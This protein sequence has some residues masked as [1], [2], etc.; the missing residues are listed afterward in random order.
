MGRALEMLKVAALM[1][2]MGGDVAA[3][4]QQK[5]DLWAVLVAGS[6]S[7]MNY[8]HQVSRQPASGTARACP[9]GIVSPEL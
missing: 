8:R 6:S 1:L 2:A 5:G 4:R 3:A 9:P 7:W